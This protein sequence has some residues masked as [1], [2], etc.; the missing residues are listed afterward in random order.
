MKENKWNLKEN[1]AGNQSMYLIDSMD[2]VRYSGALQGLKSLIN[3]LYGDKVKYE[4]EHSNSLELDEWFQELQISSVR[5]NISREFSI[6]RLMTYSKDG[7]QYIL[8]IARILI[9][10]GE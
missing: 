7:N 6:V 8:E 10:E 3:K 9:E 5:F 4:K 2:D 1:A